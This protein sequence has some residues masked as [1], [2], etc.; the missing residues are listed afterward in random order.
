MT[1][2]KPDASARLGITLINSDET[3]APRGPTAPIITALAPGCLAADS[4]RITIN[5]LL[6]AVNGQRVHTHTEATALLR[7]AVGDVELDV[8]ASGGGSGGLVPPV[9]GGAVVDDVLGAAAATSF[10][11]TG[12]ADGGK[13]GER[14]EANVHTSV[15]VHTSEDSAR[16]GGR[17]GA[18]DGVGHGLYGTGAC[19]LYTSPSPRDRQKSRMPSSA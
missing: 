5:Q 15:N 19:L 8:T 16:S 10:G 7:N 14:G 4:G 2:H 17:G 11:P 1:L 9:V 12:A 13:G 3:H 6:V 18:A